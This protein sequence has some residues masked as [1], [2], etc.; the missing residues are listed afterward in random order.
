M[1][2]DEQT[3]P[4][5]E[6]LLEFYRLILPSHTVTDIT[7][8][9]QNERL[10]IGD[11][12]IS[13]AILKLG[14]YTERLIRMRDGHTDQT[15]FTKD[16]LSEVS[17]PNLLGSAYEHTADPSITDDT[18]F[19]LKNKTLTNLKSRGGAEVS[20][21]DARLLILAGNKNIKRIPLYNSGFSVVIRGANLAEINLVHNLL[22]SELDEYGKMLGAVFYMHSDLKIK[23]ILWQFIESLIID[24]NLADWEAEDRLRL[25][26]NVALTD[27]TTILLGVLSIMYRNGYPFTHICLNDTCRNTVEEDVD[28]SLLQLTDFSRIP[29]AQK[30]FLASSGKVGGDELVEY[31]KALKLEKVIESGD[32]RLHLRP[33]SVGN[34][35]RKADTFNEEMMI[36]IHDV[37]S[38]KEINEYL[39]FS[40]TRIFE[41]WIS[42]VEVIGEDGQV[43]YKVS[44][45]E[46][47]ALVLSQIQTNGDGD[48]LIRDLQDYIKSIT[49]T[50]FGYMA[51]NCAV[52]GT[53]PSNQVEGFVPFDVQSAFFNMAVRLLLEKS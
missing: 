35:I 47:V 43:A 50:S 46:S 44:D 25:R 41:P 21:K 4:T 49:L 11:E 29:Q 3:V 12:E 53:A 1:S 10:R 38:T 19:V 51:T 17:D 5:M 36:S 7:N 33:T 27:Y 26:E 34:Y 23:T 39:S 22:N 20:G 48:Q 18:G 2:Q 8:A 6:N 24:S 13:R 30:R 40:Y 31:R 14:S 15:V 45:A 42:Y 32:Y 37:K 28:L 52:C 16:I 9:I